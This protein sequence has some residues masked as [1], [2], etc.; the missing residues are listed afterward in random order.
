M[1][2]NRNKVGS[3][4]IIDSALLDLT[5]AFPSSDFKVE[6]DKYGI[7]TVSYVKREPISITYLKHI[8]GLYFRRYDIVEE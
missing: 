4:R 6:V 7:Y 3:I 1:K 2:K 5:N 8:L